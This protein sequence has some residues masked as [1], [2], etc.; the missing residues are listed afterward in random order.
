MRRLLLLLLFAAC[1]T[2][3]DA[4]PK[5][6]EPTENEPG[7]IPAPDNDDVASAWDKQPEKAPVTPV[8]PPPEV[9][10]DRFADFKAALAD[11]QAAL[12]SKKYDDARTAIQKALSES[13]NL[14]G[15]ARHQAF[16]VAQKIE[17]G[18]ANTESAESNAR[19]WLLACGPERLD[20][21]RTAALNAL[22]A[23][24]KMKGA[25]KKLGKHAAEL[26]EAE[27]CAVKAENQRKPAPC[28]ATTQRLAKQSKD[29]LLLQRLLLG[30]ALR[31]EDEHKQVRLLEKAEA[32]CDKPQ[33]SGLRRRAIA[34]LIHHARST[35]E[36]DTAV[37][38]ALR[39]VQIIAEALPDGDRTWSRTPTLDQT[40]VSFDTKNG[41]GSCRA[42]EKKM[43]G[44]WTFHDYSRETA[45]EGLSADQ[46]RMV[47]DHFSPL[48]QECL[49]DQAKRMTPPDAQRFEV[50]WVV[51]N[52]GRVG[53]AHLRKDLDESP[54]AKCLR[55]QFVT[56]RYPRYDGEFQNVEQA[57]TVTAN[58]RRVRY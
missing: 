19:A 38:L 28:E 31:E 49:A 16:T 23:A 27:V 35:N 39:E 34:K 57:F 47:N 25:D 45:G 13:A 51:F 7:K 26:K 5:K 1:A 30:E 20:A 18:S 21:C 56:W 43:L 9:K 10:V 54:L 58:E 2:T 37:K 32:A 41:A 50:R 48:L 8:R 42:L 15:E 55:A 17:V 6:D 46:V 36:V 11:A 53:E 22:A 24:G 44:R 3:P 40:C 14:D 33:C 12:K 29:E 52:D 4:P